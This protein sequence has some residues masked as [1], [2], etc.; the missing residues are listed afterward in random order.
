MIDGETY[1]IMD[2]LVEL[3]D[4]SL[5]NIEI[6][7]NGYA[8]TEERLSCYAADLLMRQYT[9]IRG[10]RGA[11]FTY[12][13]IKKVYVIVLYEKSTAEFHR[14]ANTYFHHGKIGYDSG[15][16]L[17]MLDEYFLIALDVFTKIPYSEDNK[18]TLHAWLSLLTTEDLTDAEQ[19]MK[20]YPW[21]EPIYQEIALLRRTPEEVIG[22]WSEALRILDEN[23]LKYYV[24]ELKEELDKKDAALNEKD[25]E[26]NENYA[27]LKEKDENID[28]LKKELEALKAQLATK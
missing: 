20:Y 4:G 23:S 19:N 16:N 18:G 13:D 17:E 3:E 5:A 15:L 28:K 11:D 12:R 25:A 7:K 21:L 9:R 27:M 8:F 2:L 26:L 1:L 6:Q 22:M 24:E 10:E 14:H